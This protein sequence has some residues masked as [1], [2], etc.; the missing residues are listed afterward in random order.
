MEKAANGSMKGII[1]VNKE[2]LVSVDFNNNPHS[3]VFDTTGT[4]VVGDNFCRVAA[5][6]DNEWA[7][8]VRMLDVAKL[9]G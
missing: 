6:Y 7:F 5:W 8:S 4:Y 2:E 9:V 3:A 1:E